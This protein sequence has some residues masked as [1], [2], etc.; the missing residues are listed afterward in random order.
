MID[1]N[2]VRPKRYRLYIDESG[3]HTYEL[4]EEAEHRYLA[5]LG[6]W[7]E[8]STDYIEYSDSLAAFKRR[9]FGPRPDEPVIL[10]RSDIIN[11]KG[12]FGILRDAEIHRNFDE[13]LLE[14]VDAARFN[15]VC[16]VIDKLTH[17]ERYYSP[18]HPYHYCLTA[19]LER[20]GGWL[21]C[22]N[23]IGDVMAEARGGQ[24][25]LQ[26]GQAYQNVYTAGT[27]NI[28]NEHFQRALTSKEIKLRKKTANIAGLELAD[29]L[30]HPVKSQVLTDN[31]LITWR[32]PPFAQKL[33]QAA[34]PKLNC[35]E[36][37]GRVDGYGT[38]LL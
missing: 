28:P 1:I 21:N 6:L 7:F 5:L 26:L 25:D 38:K 32:V 14:V 4:L 29:I 19:L 30:A 23:A 16:V 3:D 10:H 36:R 37:T 18:F 22:K 13:V 35:H 15:M 27:H 17:R 34:M 31:G 2:R 9:I 12:E 8:Q 20:Y 33:L 24:E 11:R